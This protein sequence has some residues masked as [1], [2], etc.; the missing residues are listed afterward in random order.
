MREAL[1]LR[2]TDM[3]TAGEPVRIVTDG[4]PPLAGA[5]ILEKRQDALLR[6]DRLRRIL[7]HE[8]RGHADMYGVIP[9]EPTD[10]RAAFAAL[11]IHGEGY[12][13]MCGHATIAL[14][15]WLVE[16]GQVPAVEPETRF[17][18]ELPC[19]LVEVSCRVENGTV[20][21]TA[22]ES[23]PAFLD[24][25]DIEL[26]V[27]GLGKVRFDLAYGGAFYALL[28]ASRLGL[29]FFDTPLEE[30][31]SAARALTEA[32]RA[33]LD[34]AHPDAADL[35]FLYGTILTDDAAPPEATWN[36]CV[37]A[38]GQID[39]SPTGSGVTARMA[40]DHASGLVLPGQERLFLGPTGIG[41]S[42]CVTERTG[43]PGAD[44]VRIRVS[45]HS[46]YCGTAVFTVDDGDEL[47]DG[48]SLPRT[49]RDIARGTD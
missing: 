46:H 35:G 34:I 13:T 41:F 39:R 47:G 12:S 25:A 38:D 20:T 5:T 40:R 14:G 4:Y 11:F 28:P 26:A 21:A 32:A 49:F 10:P 3:H 42:G 17:F 30:L 29:P 33:A 1:R 18:I 19:G 6:H 37:F 23:V 9:V 8:P 2:V 45:G 15:K 16:S 31:V 24:R 43:A 36:L 27:P 7:V 48:F 44:A 22:F